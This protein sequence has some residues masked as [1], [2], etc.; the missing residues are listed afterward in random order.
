MQ[1]NFYSN[2]LETK[3]GKIFKFKNSTVSCYFVPSASEGADFIFVDSLS[4]DFILGRISRRQKKIK[5][6]IFI[7]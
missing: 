7:F 5:K 3:K 6:N 4:K 1:L 2:K